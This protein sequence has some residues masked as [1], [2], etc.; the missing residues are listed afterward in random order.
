MDGGQQWMAM[1]SVTAT[2]WQ[3]TQRQWTARD[4]SMVTRGG[5]TRWNGVSVTVMDRERNGD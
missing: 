5:W 1:D 2:Q 3:W 4:G